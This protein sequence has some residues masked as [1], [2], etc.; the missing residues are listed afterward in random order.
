MRFIWA[1]LFVGSVSGLGGCSGS[2]S[3]PISVS[4]TAT[5]RALDQDLGLSATVTATVAND[6][7][8]KGVVWGLAGPGTLSSSAGS[9]VSYLPP[10]TALASGQQVTV[11]ATSVADKANSASVQITVNPL[12]SIPSQTLANGTVGVAYSQPIALKGGTSPFQWTVYN[13]SIVTGSGVGGSLPDGLTLNAATGIISG[14][15]TGAGTWYFEGTVT[16]ADGA[17]AVGPFLSIQINPGVAAAGNP[18]PSLNQPL[19]P[20]AVLPG[21][22]GTTLK[23]RGTGFV[24]GATID[25]NGTAL[26]TT[27]VNS[28][29]LSAVLPAT[30]VAAAGTASITVVNPA[31]GGGSSNVV[32]FQV[33]APET[34]V[35]FVNA[36]NSPLQ[37]PEPA[38]L[39][40]AD[41]NQD[42]KPDLA[43]AANV[44]VYT[45]L[46]NGDGTFTS[47]PGSPV[48][49]PSPPYDD[50]ASPYLGPMA[51]G[52]FDH[53]GHPGLAV[54]EFQN[55]A[56][57]I[58]LG[59]GTGSLSPSSAGFVNTEGM[60]TSA[61][62]TADFNADGNLDLAILNSISGISPI[63]L[64]YGDGAFSTAGNISPGSAAA[65]G[66]FNGDGKLDV[67]V[68]GGEDV[69]ISLGNGDGSFTQTNG[70]P[71]PVGHGFSAIVAGDFNGDGKL[72]L[73]MADGIGNAVVVLLGNGDGTFQSP[74]T[75]AAGNGP[76]AMVAGDFNND[77][78]LD[79]AIAN[80]GDGTVTLLLGNGNGTF[81]Q[82]SKSPYLV[83]TGPDAI[84][85][86]DFNGDGK[87]DLAVANGT[88]GEGTVS[89]LL[90]Q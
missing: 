2:T 67:A 14:T 63:A 72:D 60:P 46:S 61:I 4:V 9:S 78:K 35:N 81:T 64:G 48:S 68:A 29:G 54:A 55:E 19:V 17:S 11:T 84:V 47:A 50:F 33:G 85:A 49:V 43:A 26:A 86:A 82:A 27:F 28:E 69:L 44:R 76:A 8:G 83:G 16:D 52:D 36:P 66:D 41:F 32:Y 74:I 1:V 34:T 30:D 57:V 80:Y 25:F 56:A 62:E 70:S 24:S 23:V 7:S 10:A 39:A 75:I 90:Q 89:I 21:S 87:L 6:S 79:L 58:L 45:M 12:P 18:V 59:N 13:G 31:P 37:V 51:V 88:D 40:V 3:L 53:S 65:V 77:G 42:G 73:A 15:P 22:S 20:A 5:P 71:V 38:A